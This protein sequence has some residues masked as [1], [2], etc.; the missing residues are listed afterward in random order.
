MGVVLDCD[1]GIFA[2]NHSSHSARCFIVLFLSL[3]LF[4]HEEKEQ[5]TGTHFVIETIK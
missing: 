3:N 1:K 5:N 4:E 2:L